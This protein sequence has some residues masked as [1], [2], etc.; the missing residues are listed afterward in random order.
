METLI[1]L[2]GI[3]VVPKYIDWIIVGALTGKNGWLPA[4]KW[5]KDIIKMARP[6]PIFIKDNVMW[7]E[8]IQEFPV[9]RCFIG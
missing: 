8:K 3:T 7:K 2:S 1:N 6:R 5:V 4:E 9:R